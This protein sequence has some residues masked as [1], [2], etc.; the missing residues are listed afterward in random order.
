MAK[1][2]SVAPK[3][4]INI[5]YKPAT[6]DAKEDVELPNKVVMVGDYTLREEEEDLQ[7][8]ELIDI[9]K[10]NFSDV[11]AS[12]RLNVQ[13]TVPNK[14]S[15]EEDAEM[16]ASL[17]FNNLRDFEPESVVKQVPELAKLLELREALSFLKGPL[18][19]VPAFRKQIEELLGDDDSRQKLM[20]ELGI[21]E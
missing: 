1:D 8:R 6:G 13:M 14:L 12:Q 3:E 10:D 9:N 17:T 4:R 19:N 21:E 11:M 15:G 16:S 18:G 7:D 2:G 5:V 20:A